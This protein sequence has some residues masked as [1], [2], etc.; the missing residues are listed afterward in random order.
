VERKDIARGN[1]REL[2]GGVLV[3]IRQHPYSV[4]KLGPCDYVFCFVNS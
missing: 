4:S 2:F 1:H 3:G